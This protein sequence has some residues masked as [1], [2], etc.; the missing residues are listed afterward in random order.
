[1]VATGPN[2][3]HRGYWRGEVDPLG[4]RQQELRT[5]CRRTGAGGEGRLIGLL[6]GIGSFLVSSHSVHLTTAVV[7]TSSAL[8]SRTG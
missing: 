3:F 7:P 4:F 1:M 6:I 2:G 8:R 5:A